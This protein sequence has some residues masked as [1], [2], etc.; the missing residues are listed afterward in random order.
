MWNS[1]IFSAPTFL[2]SRF[3]VFLGVFILNSNTMENQ[4]D[5]VKIVEITDENFEAE[6]PNIQKTVF[7]SAFVAFDMEFSGLESKSYH[8][9][10][11][12]DSVDLILCCF[13]I[14]LKLVIVK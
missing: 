8:K 4:E 13:M 3:C 10:V 1:E 2:N 6:F 14:S 5:Y 12:V 9:S 7:E 11:S